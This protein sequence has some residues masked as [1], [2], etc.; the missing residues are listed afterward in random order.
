[1]SSLTEVLGA[2]DVIGVL[3]RNTSLRLVNVSVSGCLLESAHRFE[4]GT[5][6]MLE[7][8]IGEV[9]HADAVRVCRVQPV[10]GSGAAWHLGVEFLWT[11]PPGS[12]SLRRMV[13]RLRNHIA[14]QTLKAAFAV[15]RLM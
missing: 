10:F 2:D 6:G 9:T 12:R 3:T 8:T 4:P 14:Q 15:G 7:V 5:T 1:M 13:S 11:T